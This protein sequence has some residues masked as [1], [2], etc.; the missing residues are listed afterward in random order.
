MRKIILTISLPLILIFL[1][2][3][4]VIADC[5]V[6][7]WAWAGGG[8]IN[9]VA[10]ATI[11]WISFNSTDYGGTI[12]YGVRLSTSTGYF[13]GYAWAEN[14]GW[15]SFNR[16]E[17]G[18]PPSDDPCSYGGCIAKVE[19]TTTLGTSDTKVLGW[20]R[21]ISAI[22]GDPSITGG[23][24][25]WIK[26]GDTHGYWISATNPADK[27][28][29]IDSNGDF[30]GWAWSGS[31]SASSSVLGWISFNSSD[32]NAGGNYKVTLHLPGPPP[33]PPPPLTADFDWTPDIIFTYTLITFFATNPSDCTDCTYAWQFE[34]GAHPPSASGP[35][36]T[37]VYFSS[38]G[39]K[40][41][42]LTVTSSEESFVPITK[43]VQ[44]RP[45]PTPGFIFQGIFA[46]IFYFLKSFLEKIF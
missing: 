6:T 11:G 3:S 13:S 27:Q 26:L 21:V 38:P 20:A 24:D 42:T 28:V 14:I 36:V 46:K 25:G 7:G 12:P 18:A 30:H 39:Y 40:N 9:D 33:P 5:D 45:R 29:Y 16:S 1:S 15:I 4:E 10:T 8:K 41:V 2:V 43:Q 32:P 31:S 17:T 23:W 19:S 35:R 37:G 22:S 34:D 44:V